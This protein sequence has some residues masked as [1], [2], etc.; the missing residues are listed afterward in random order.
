MSSVK[1]W[2]FCLSLAVGKRHIQQREEQEADMVYES[3]L[4]GLIQLQPNTKH[5]I[6]NNPAGS[7]A[8][9]GIKIYIVIVQLGLL[10]KIALW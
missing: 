7:L 6:R 3:G 2:P 10:K 8:G 1:W 4:S 9:I 5:G